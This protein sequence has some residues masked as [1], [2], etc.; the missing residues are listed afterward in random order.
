MLLL[1]WWRVVK[2]VGKNI[3]FLTLSWCNK[4][5][6]CTIWLWHNQE[7]QLLLKPSAVTSPS[8]QVSSWGYYTTWTY[9]WTIQTRV[10][11]AQYMLSF[12]VLALAPIL[13]SQPCNNIYARCSSNL[14]SSTITGDALWLHVDLHIDH[15][16]HLSNSSATWR[17]RSKDAEINCSNA[18]YV[19]VCPDDLILL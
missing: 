9:D 17:F 11:L 19:G 16:T 5:Y 6:N 3:T 13:P 14:H 8:T 18:R 12:A 2:T 15:N 7:P 10:V 4:K 1:P